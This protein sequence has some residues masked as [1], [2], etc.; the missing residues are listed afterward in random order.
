[1]NTLIPAITLVVLI[2]LAYFLG[3]RQERRARKGQPAEPRLP[4]GGAR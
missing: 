2:S 1:M 4:L 3:R